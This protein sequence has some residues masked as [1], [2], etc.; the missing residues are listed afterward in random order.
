M[1][2]GLTLLLS[3]SALANEKKS[4]KFI[5]LPLVLQQIALC[6]AGADQHK[7]NGK[8]IRSRT[9]DIGIMQINLKVHFQQATKAGYDIF[10]PN[11]NMAYGLWLYQK[12]GLAPWYAS[13]ACWKKHLAML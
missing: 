13:R 8:L 1:V 9:N 7:D 4:I 5:E 12:H 11:G 10:N 6:E 2:L 3:N